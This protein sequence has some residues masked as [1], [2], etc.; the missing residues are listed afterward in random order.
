MPTPLN[1]LDFGPHNDAVQEV[2]TFAQSG[3]LLSIP[4]DQ[5]L[6]ESSGYQIKQIH[7]FEEIDLYRKSLNDCMDGY[8]PYIKRA[9]WNELLRDDIGKKMNY[10]DTTGEFK[11][12]EKLGRSLTSQFDQLWDQ[13]FI[14]VNDQLKEIL[15]KDEADIIADNLYMICKLRALFG[16]DKSFRHETLFPIFQAGGYPCGW[17]GAFPRG[18]VAVFVPDPCIPCTFPQKAE[19]PDFTDLEAWESE[20]EE[21]PDLI[22]SQKPFSSDQPRLWHGITSLEGEYAYA[23]IDEHIQFALG[24]SVETIWPEIVEQRENELNAV[25]G[26]T[27][28]EPIP[29]PERFIISLMLTGVERTYLI[30][31]PENQYILELVQEIVEMN[32]TGGFFFEVSN[33]N[34]TVRFLHYDECGMCDETLEADA[35]GI[36]F[37]SEVRDLENPLEQENLFE[38]VNNCFEYHGLCDL[39]LNYDALITGP[40]DQGLSTATLKQMPELKYEI[41][42]I[43]LD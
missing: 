13:F 15:I 21:V 25:W 6:A 38:I 5:Q 11:A 18:Q 19:P 7:T 23:A 17:S 37:E 4:F 33:Q 41:D 14:L 1:Q 28:G 27:A 24:W 31:H 2:I 16:K 42:I 8:E 35:D 3:K 30:S 10:G 36:L 9:D 32:E 29:L 22:R 12:I 43:N 40:D 26:D 20:T 34:Q 39:K